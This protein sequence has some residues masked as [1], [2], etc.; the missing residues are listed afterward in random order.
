MRSK[1]S[2]KRYKK[3]QRPQNRFFLKVVG[4]I[5]TYWGISWDFF[6]VCTGGYFEYRRE[7]CVTGVAQ[8][9][10]T[11]I[12]QPQGRGFESRPPWGGR[13]RSII[14]NQRERSKKWGKTMKK[15]KQ[16]Q[17]MS[18][19]VQRPQNRFFI[20]FRWKIGQPYRALNRALYR[21]R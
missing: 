21:A 19:K 14:I 1:K 15:V 2:Q 7:F 5:G 12:S 6:L 10:G 8:W 17:K 9:F 20:E 3:V 11:R 4:H 16:C 13:P 18:K